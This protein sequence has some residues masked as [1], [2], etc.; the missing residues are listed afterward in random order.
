MVYAMEFA[1]ALHTLMAERAISGNVLARRVPCDKALISRYVNGHQAPSASM[2]ARIDE[3][4]GADGELAALAAR[5]HRSGLAGPISAD[6]EDDV[7]RRAF[8]GAGLLG[9]IELLRQ[10]VDGALDPV[11]T[12]RDAEEWERVAAEIGR[13][14]V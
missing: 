9:G 5:P 12:R 3:L 6:C 4:L 1:E 10:H 11:T 13:A 7:R 8:L 14:H 2:A